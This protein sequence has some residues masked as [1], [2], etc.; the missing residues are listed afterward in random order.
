MGGEGEGGGEGVI[1]AHLYALV[2]FKTSML[3]LDLRGDSL[4]GLAALLSKH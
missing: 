4:P 3:T 1:G 2:D